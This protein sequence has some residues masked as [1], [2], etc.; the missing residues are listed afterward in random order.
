MVEHTSSLCM[1]CRIR[2]TSSRSSH[3]TCAPF[4]S[5]AWWTGLALGDRK[6]RHLLV[7]ILGLAL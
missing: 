5:R 4:S 6:R 7:K 2:R 3:D 1:S